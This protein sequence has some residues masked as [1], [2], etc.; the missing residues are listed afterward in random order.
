MRQR[1]RE[2]FHATFSIDEKLYESLAG[3]EVFYLRADPLR[4]PLV[5]YLGH[6]AVFYVNKLNIAR[7]LSRRIN[8]RFESIFAVGVDEMSWDDLNE[9]HY[10]W[11]GIPEVRAYRDQVRALVDD[12]I[13]QMPLEMPITWES[14]WWA[15]MMGIEHQRIHLET[16]SVL[17]RHLPLD[18]VKELDFFTIC[19]QAVMHRSIA[20][21]MCP[22]ERSL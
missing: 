2:Y 17:I 9:A 22:G 12:L 19:P 14:P 13:T 18:K 7:I 8:P 4:H 11:P 15:I 5:F 20:W 1:I 6:T 10:D 16:S 3:D 21:S